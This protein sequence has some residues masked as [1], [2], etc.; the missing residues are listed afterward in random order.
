MGAKSAE[1]VK[2]ATRPGQYPSPDLPEVAFAGRSN[3]GKSS[4]INSL[5]GRKKLVKT[6]STPGRTQL[7]NFFRIND[8]YSFVDLPGY[9][10]A[11]VPKHVKREWAP[12]MEKYFRTRETLRGV[13]LI[14]D[15]R[16][17]P[18][19]EEHALVDWLI[20]IG[21]PCLLVATKAD[22]LS[23]NKL[24][25]RMREVSRAL[26][27]DRDTVIPFS[28]KTGRGGD[29]VWAAITAICEEPSEHEAGDEAGPPSDG[30][31]ETT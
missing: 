28:A 10:Y 9:G 19:E 15:V 25:V 5:V 30:A 6:S 29:K 20:E 31:E 22:K 12:M 24:A 1:F 17:D 26:G 18:G 8:R 7:I 14:L 27:V 13:V 3:V 11:K 23:G 2:S 16:R 4:L 21:R